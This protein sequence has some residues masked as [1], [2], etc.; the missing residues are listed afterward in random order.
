[1]RK[2]PK[3]EIVTQAKEI[4]PTTIGDFFLAKSTG[5]DGAHEIAHPSD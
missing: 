1:L 5:S 2:S 3:E 4:T